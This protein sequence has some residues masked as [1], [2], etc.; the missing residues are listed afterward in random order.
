MKKIVA[1]LLALVMVSALF[2]C[3]SVSAFADNQHF[4]KLTLEF[5]PSKD[6]DVIIA[7]TANLPELVQAEMARLGYDIDE[8]DITV[9]TSYAATGEAMSAGSIDVGWLPAGTYILYSDDTDVILTATRNGLSNDSEDPAT[10]NGEANKTLK[11]GPQVTYYRALIYATPSE[12]GKELAAKVNAGEALTWDDLNKASWAVLNNS[13]N[14]GYIYP[15]MWL[16]NNYDGKKLTDLDRVTTLE[17]YGP[18]FSYAAAESVDIIVCYAD[19]RNDYEASWTIPETEV[20]ETGKQGLGRPDSIWNELNVIGVTDG[21]YNDTVAISKESP[22]YTPEIVEA[23]QDCFI[24]IINTD[25]GKAIFD[26]YSHTGYAKAVDSDY[27]NSRIA[28]QLLN[29]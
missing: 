2:V 5:V 6:A 14:A 22:Y 19:G 24:N 15:T 11:N 28:M 9:G 18:A 17:G 13:S 3:G 8:V 1:M 26:I 20:D 21:I 25:E 29:G 27:D 23:L 4:D 10:W 16:M 12:Y 7:G